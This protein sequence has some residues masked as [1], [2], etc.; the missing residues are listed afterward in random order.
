MTGTDERI[1]LVALK[2]LLSYAEGDNDGVMAAL[3]SAG[4]SVQRTAELISCLADFIIGSIPDPVGELRK[5]VLK[6]SGG[7]AFVREVA[8]A[9][10]PVP[11]DG[12]APVGKAG[13]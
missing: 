4:E 5:A 3:Q 10:V 1:E 2:F 9:P 13:S 8:D 6:A 7:A 12:N 11:G